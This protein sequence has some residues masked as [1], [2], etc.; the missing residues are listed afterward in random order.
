M[1]LIEFLTDDTLVMTVTSNFRKDFKILK[2]FFNLDFDIEFPELNF[3]YKSFNKADAQEK[4]TI[5]G[6]TKVKFIFDIKRGEHYVISFPMIN[7]YP[8]VIGE[9]I[10][11]FDFE[12]EIAAFIYFSR[13]TLIHELIH[14][15]QFA[16][17]VFFSELLQKDYEKFDSKIT[18]E[19]VEAIEYKCVSELVY[20]AKSRY[21]NDKIL[22]EL[23]NIELLDFGYLFSKINES[24]YENEMCQ[25]METLNKLLL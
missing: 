7:F 11:R 14:Y 16:N 23:V 12:N 20:I 1:K 17:K 9:Y 4:R 10:R 8:T 18:S 22:N 5:F 25:C 6:C 24:K 15:F 13:I 3:V 21:K 19:I 2:A